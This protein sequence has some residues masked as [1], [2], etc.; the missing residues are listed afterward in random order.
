M[1]NLSRAQAL[2]IVL[3][4][5]ASAVTCFVP[6][7]VIGN[8]MDRTKLNERKNSDRARVEKNLEDMMN[9]DWREFRARLVAQENIE[10]KENPRKAKNTSMSKAPRDYH[11]PQWDGGIARQEKLSNIFSGTISSIFNNNNGSKNNQNH[12]NRMN[13]FS[14]KSSRSSI[15]DGDSVGGLSPNSPNPLSFEDPFVSVDEIPVL[16]QP[17]VKLDKHRWAHTISHIEAGCVL[18]ANEK[19]G[20]IFHQTVVLIVDH[21]ETTGTT[22]VI[23]NRP[24]SGDLLKIASETESNVDLSLKLAFHSSTVGYGGPVMQSEYSIVHGY[25]EVEGS[26]KVAHG[27]FVGGSEEL[28]NERRK[29]KLEP[30]EALFVK[31]HAAWVPGQLE[32]EI[33]KGVWYVA[34][35]SSDFILRYAGAPVYPNDNKDDLWSD[36]LT[37]MGGEYSDIASKYAFRGDQRLKP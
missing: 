21:Q 1:N 37:S 33:S 6:N 29:N 30:G 13:S 16:M 8:H 24:M 4:I 3:T 34:S 5:Q 14:G 19:L 25:G 27:L 10:E 35:V 7:Y 2:L 22:G 9:N 23:I 17:K 15:F 11:S 31:G 32:R 20:G 12:G 36:I 26:R 18:I 28:L